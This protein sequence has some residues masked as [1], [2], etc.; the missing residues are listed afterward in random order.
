MA[1]SSGDGPILRRIR[2][3]GWHCWFALCSFGAFGRGSSRRGCM[4]L[5]STALAA[6]VFC[7]W[8]LFYMRSEQYVRAAYGL[9][10]QAE[11]GEARSVSSVG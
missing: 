6:G 1:V 10:E 4:R 2:S 8:P 11:G 5:L 3:P 7:L 9:S